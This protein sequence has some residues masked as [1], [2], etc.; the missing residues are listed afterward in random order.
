M[1]LYVRIYIVVDSERRQ[2]A[3]TTHISNAKQSWSEKAQG[4][5][6]N[7]PSSQHKCL[8]RCQSFREGMTNGISLLFFLACRR[9]IS[10]LLRYCRNLYRP[11]YLWPNGCKYE[12]L[13]QFRCRAFF[14]RNAPTR[15]MLSF[16]F[17]Q[18]TYIHPNL[19]F[20]IRF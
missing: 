2:S 1:R 14:F 15:S 6:T 5:M 18:S 17:V 8:R 11:Q 16:C 13:L 3:A 7:F 12:T 10:R 9:K 20:L 4:K 19:D